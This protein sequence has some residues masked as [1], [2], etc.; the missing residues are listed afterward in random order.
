MSNI[1]PW[2]V[3]VLGMGT[4]FVGLVVLIL[5]T[6]LMSNLCGVHKGKGVRS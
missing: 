1:S 6:D 2:F 4:V 5:I 3:M